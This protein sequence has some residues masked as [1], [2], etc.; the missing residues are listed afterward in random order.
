MS[1]REAK[2]RRKQLYKELKEETKAKRK[3]IDK[4]LKEEAKA[5]MKPVD[6]ELK[7]GKEPFD[8]TIKILVL[9]EDQVWC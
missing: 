8:N 4:E 1:N 5:R 6:K 3:E 7:R 2:A 9:G